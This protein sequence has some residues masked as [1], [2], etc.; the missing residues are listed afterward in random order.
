MAGMHWG[1]FDLTDEPVDLPPRVLEEVLQREGV[2][3]ERVRALAVGE[4][5]IIAP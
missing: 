2:D 5:W 1:T 3:R 4:R